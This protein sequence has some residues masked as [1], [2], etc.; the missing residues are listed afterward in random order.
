MNQNQQRQLDAF[1]RAQNFLDSHAGEVAVLK[2]CE[3]RKQLDDAVAQIGASNTEQGTSIRQ[4]DGLLSRQHAL[5]SELRSRHMQP[6]ATFARARL[7]GVPDFAAL[8]RSTLRLQ[9]K[10][11][12]HA[13]HAMATAA[14]PH[15]DI[16]AQGGFPDCIAKLNAA[17]D[18]V[19][20]AME[21]RANTRVT[22]VRAS[23]EL[24]DQV[25]RGVKALT[26]LHAVVNN[27][28]GHDATFMAGWK[29]ARRVGLKIGAVHGSRTSLVAAVA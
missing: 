2:N 5:V 8:T 10:P 3:G 12:V 27:V 11:L 28:F 6:I 20:A 13:A 9:P 4:M 29:S 19:T 26:M 24:H 16:L 17:A 14:A 15:A 21:D 25:Q 22:K 7:H 1:R 18:A 23:K